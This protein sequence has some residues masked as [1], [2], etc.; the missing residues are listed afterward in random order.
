MRA[1]AFL[2][3][4]CNDNE[5]GHN[6]VGMRLRFLAEY[7]MQQNIDL[8]SGQAS[9]KSRAREPRVVKVRE[10]PKKKRCLRRPA[11]AAALRRPAAAAAA[12]AEEQDKDAP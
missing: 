9:S 6:P 8:L 5:S 4:L 2:E 12:A 11:A 7:K 10:A 3:K 1:Q